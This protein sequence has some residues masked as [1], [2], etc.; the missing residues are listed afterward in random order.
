[1]Q[2]LIW[3]YPDREDVYNHKLNNIHDRLLVFMPRNLSNPNINK[4]F[5]IVTILMA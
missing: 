5:A 4:N 2:S 1:M 3:Q